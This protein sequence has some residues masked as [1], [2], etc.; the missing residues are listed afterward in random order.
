MELVCRGFRRSI[1]SVQRVVEVQADLRYLKV[2]GYDQGGLYRDNPVR[3]TL[4]GNYD[5]AERRTHEQIIYR[6]REQS[7]ER[8]LSARDDHSLPVEQPRRKNR[9]VERAARR[10]EPMTYP[11]S[12]R[13]KL[14]AEA[15]YDIVSVPCSTMNPS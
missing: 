3:R 10:T 8:D 9:V 13:R 2:T 5:L 6:I 1:A 4:S 14:K 15:E 12:S 7:R 11:R